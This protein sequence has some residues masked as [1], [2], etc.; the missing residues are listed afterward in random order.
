MECAEVDALRA[1]FVER[2]H[3]EDAFHLRS[4]K[5]EVSM[6]LQYL[7]PKC[8]IGREMFRLNSTQPLGEST[9]NNQLK[10]I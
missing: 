6:S 8:D 7:G 9:T 10:A 1:A 3:G 4:M 5:H 2:A